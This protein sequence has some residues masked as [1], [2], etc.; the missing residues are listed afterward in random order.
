MFLVPKNSL[1]SLALR[2]Y[3]GLAAIVFFCGHF[4]ERNTMARPKKTQEER[5]TRRVKFDLTPSDY[6]QSLKDSQKAGMT[7]TAY[8]RQQF[9]NGK[10]I[11]HKYRKLDYDTFEQLRR[12]GVNLNQ[13]T[14]AVNQSGN[15]PDHRLS[16]I[17]LRLEDVLSKTINDSDNNQKRN[18]L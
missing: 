12:I 18:K 2:G 4:M 5:L 1:R 13:L 14:R 15:I 7:L 6:A 17:C 9:L 3:N 16:N 8:A 11:I 10:V